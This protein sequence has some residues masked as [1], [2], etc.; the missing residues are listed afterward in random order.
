MA[1]LAASYLAAEGEKL[2]RALRTRG[3]PAGSGLDGE[4]A[5]AAAGIE[6]RLVAAELGLAE[7]GRA[8][9]GATRGTGVEESGCGGC[10]QDEG[11]AEVSGEWQEAYGAGNAE[12][13]EEDAGRAGAG[14]AST[15]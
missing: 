3:G 10:P 4:E 15:L 7:A 12:E 9:G 11:A 2:V 5:A 6:Q 8:A 14:V 1:A 13:D